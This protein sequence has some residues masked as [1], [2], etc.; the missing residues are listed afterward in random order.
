ML[1]NILCI[2]KIYFDI[3]FLIFILNFVK[4]NILIDDTADGRLWKETNRTLKEDG[5]GKQEN[6]MHGHQ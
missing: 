1:N 5:S 2:V 6:W 4:F 3:I